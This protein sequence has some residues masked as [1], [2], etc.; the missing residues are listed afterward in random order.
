MRTRAWPGAHWVPFLALSVGCTPLL[1]V[2]GFDYGTGGS[3]GAGAAPDG[4]H[5]G[6]D[7]G[8]DVGGT[9]NAGG[10]GGTTSTASGGAGGKGGATMVCNDIEDA[11]TGH[12]YAHLD[13]NVGT[14]D[15]GRT[16]CMGLGAGWDIVA[17]SSQQERDFLDGKLM[18]VGTWL[19]ARDVLDN[20][21]FQWVNG[22]TWG[23][24]PWEAGDPNGG[25]EDCIEL[26]QL[27]GDANDEFRDNPCTQARAP[28]CEWPSSN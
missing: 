2:D 10:T 8:D 18:M 21:T 16:L 5:G 25:D 9:M 22:E 20:D 19:G 11:Q 6:G 12:C 23:Y 1:D 24:A 3:G 26:Q 28:L 14:W 17:I 27:N 15:A 7:G 4:G 13:T